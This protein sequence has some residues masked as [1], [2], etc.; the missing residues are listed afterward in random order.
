MRLRHGTTSYTAV[1][2]A[3]AILS[4]KNMFYDIHEVDV[5]HSQTV[6]AAD[7]LKLAQSTNCWVLTT[8]ILKA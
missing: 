2:G 7:S 8:D 5:G 4:G 1:H 3:A 6:G